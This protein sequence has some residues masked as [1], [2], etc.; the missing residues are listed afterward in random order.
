MNHITTPLK[1]FREDINAIRSVAI[2][3]VLIYHFNFFGFETGW[4]GVDIFF[5]ISGYLMTAII[6]GKIEKEKFSFSEFYLSRLRRVFPALFF[7][8]SVVLLFGYFYLPTTDLKNLA[9][10]IRYGVIFSSNFYLLENANYFDR[11]SI[12][13]WFLHLWSLS[14]EAQF[15]LFYPIV[16][17]FSYKYDKIKTVTYAVLSL[18]MASF[19]INFYFQ[20]NEMKNMAF[21]SIISR[22]WEFILGG[23]A[24]FIER[25][26]V[27][28]SKLTY[29]LG[30]ATMILS[31]VFIQNGNLEWVIIPVIATMVVIAG[32]RSNKF[33]DN[34]IVQYVGDRSY[35]IYLWHWVLIVFLHYTSQFESDIAKISMLIMS[36]IMAEFSYQFIEKPTRNLNKNTGLKIE[37]YIIFVLIVGMFFGASYLHKNSLDRVDTKAEKIAN[38]VLNHAH[39]CL[40]VEE[41]IL[42]GKKGCALYSGETKAFLI[43][44]SHAQAAASALE[45][46]LKIKFGEEKSIEFRGMSGCATIKDAIYSENTFAES[47]E[48]CKT[49]NDDLLKELSEKKVSP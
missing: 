37:G 7:V 2:L 18:L 14:V 29:T 1:N 13:R 21:Y 23:I 11:F 3:S 47:K 30:W 17:Y 35:S 24:Y 42:D 40:L 44:D 46:A 31:A 48:T 26:K 34:D 9:N 12:E 8:M 33:I 22:E 5:V 28:V 15:Y 39:G 36:F 16:L 27:I 25:N 45:D 49:F 43:G 10:E 32:N 38:E 20:F 41:D 6:L 4:I 19:A